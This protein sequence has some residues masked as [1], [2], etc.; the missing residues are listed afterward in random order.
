MRRVIRAMSHCRRAVCN[1]RRSERV[2]I[3]KDWKGVA[4]AHNVSGLHSHNT[5]ASRNGLL[6]SHALELLRL[7]NITTLSWWHYLCDQETQRIFHFTFIIHNSNSSTLPSFVS[8]STKTA[9]IQSIMPHDFMPLAKERRHPQ[10]RKAAWL[11]DAT[12]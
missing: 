5:Y 3:R 10:H 4:Q 8:I 7:R 12:G 9:I 11:R 2:S 1:R 6:S